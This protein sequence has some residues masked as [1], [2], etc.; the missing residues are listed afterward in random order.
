MT[1]EMF[2]STQLEVPAYI[3]ARI[4]QNKAQDIRSSIFDS[5]L[6]DGDFPPRISIRAARF[7]MVESAVE[8]MIGTDLDVVIVGA[9]PHSSKAYYAKQYNPD[10]D[11]VQLPDCWSDNG[12]RPD[13][14]VADP[15][16]TS[17]AECP[18]NVLGSKINP[19]GAKSKKCGDSRLL[20]VVPASD[21]SKVY[22]LSV[23]VGSMKNMREYFKHLA[24]YGVDPEMVVTK[25]SFDEEASAPKLVFA[26][27]KFVPEKAVEA[28]YA[29]GQTAEVKAAIRVTDEAPA[30]A[31]PAAKPKP[32]LTVVETPPV[33][34]VQ[35]PLIDDA[36]ED[37]P[38]PPPVAAKPAA[39]A[40]KPAKKEDA[41]PSVAAS[42]VDAALGDMF[43]D[44]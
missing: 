31:A 13:A 24:N 1:E 20:A 40:V 34:E 11:D 33:A 43:G 8:T 41:T 44:D 4:Q 28:M 10:S 15:V 19:S 22:Q 18:Y 25:L 38:A 36:Y 37:E 26:Q 12:I 32:A 35:L 5:V 16:C 17:C 7:R 23:P 14:R 29:L 9:N 3:A 21:P 30:L 6:G 2:M 42:R 39:K 27:K